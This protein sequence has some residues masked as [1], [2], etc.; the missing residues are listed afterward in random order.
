MA[1]NANG[2]H[3]ATQG[4][5]SSIAE[6]VRG[7][8]Q[9]V[10]DMAQ[11]FIREAI[12]QGAFPPGQRL[13]LDEIASILGISRMPVRASLRQLES[14]GL[15]R[16]HPYRGA[17]V[18]ILSAEEIAEI[19]EMRVLVECYLV[20]RA[21]PR[22]D[23]ALMERLE[24]KAAELDSVDPEDL[25]RGLD[26]RRELY[27]MLYEQAGRPRALDLANQLR[28]SVGRYLLLQRVDPGHGHEVFMGHVHA[29]DVDGAKKWL[30]SHLLKVSDA[31]QSMAAAQGVGSD[32]T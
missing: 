29:R 1:N 4:Q 22:A 31:L 20:E 14:E 32:A 27:Q 15:L 13:N 17:T 30:S 26:V 3:P 6:A 24:A 5:L 12:H 18:S 7:P 28:G 21:I 9:T 11:S 25:G 10:E 16:I 23:E 8:F 2:N 19:Y